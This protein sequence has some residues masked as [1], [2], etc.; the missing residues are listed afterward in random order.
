[1]CIYKVL[2]RHKN[3]YVI[4]CNECNHYQLTFG[5]TGV[6]FEE[7]EF[8]DFCK[9]IID[10]QSSVNATTLNNEKRIKIDLSHDSM[11]M[12]LNRF[13][14]KDLYEIICEA[15]FNIEIDNLLTDLN[16]ITE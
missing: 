14:L 7:A 2:A 13:E 12:I 16:L 15:K 4:F 10:L 8:P 9:Y 1:M 11:M 3:G 6:S 5:T